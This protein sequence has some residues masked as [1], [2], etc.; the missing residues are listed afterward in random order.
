M[1]GGIATVIVRVVNGLLRISKYCGIGTASAVPSKYWS[2]N[3][4][5]AMTR[6]MTAVALRS[7]R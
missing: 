5:T 7:W 4:A 2:K 3:Q 1:A 6:Y